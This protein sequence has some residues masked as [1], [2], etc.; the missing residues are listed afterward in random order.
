MK[1]ISEG[2]GSSIKALRERALAIL[3]FIESADSLG[4]FDLDFRAIVE[5]SA[6]SGNVRRLRLLMREIEGL[7][8][9]LPLHKQD[10]LDALLHQALGVDRDAEREEALAQ[11]RTILKRGVISSEKQRKHLEDFL[12][13]LQPGEEVSPEAIAVAALLRAFP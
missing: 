2:R 8:L 13:G 7:A 12:D 9:A 10:G 6:S 4:S 3:N 5:Q 1:P 11:V